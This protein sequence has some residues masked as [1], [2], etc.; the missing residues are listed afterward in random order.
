MN[1]IPTW[2]LGLLVVA[3]VLGFTTVALADESKG[4]IKSVDADKMTV[5]VTVDTKDVTYTATKDT[6]ITVAGKDAKFADL[7]KDA[8]VT[9]TWKKDGDKVV[10]SAIAA[11]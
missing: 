10:V 3:L 7:K 8:K 4:T 9:V 1:R 2:F 6:K 5:T 11:S